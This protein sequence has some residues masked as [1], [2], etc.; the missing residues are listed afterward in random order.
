MASSEETL[1]AQAHEVVIGLRCSDEVRK[2][3]MD[4]YESR[5]CE[6]AANIKTNIGSDYQA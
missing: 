3:F 6:V 5:R 4:N 1:L 2:R